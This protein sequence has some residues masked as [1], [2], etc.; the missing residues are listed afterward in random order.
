MKGRR[1][2]AHH[3]LRAHQSS[4]KTPTRPYCTVTVI[5]T[6]WES[7]PATA[8]TFTCVVP[9][10]VPVVTFREFPQAA[11]NPT[12]MTISTSG[13]ATLQDSSRVLVSNNPKIPAQTNRTRTDS[14]VGLDGCPTH[15]VILAAAFLAVVVI[16][17]C[18]VPAC[19]PSSVTEGGAKAHVAAAGRLLQAKET[20]CVEP[21]SGVTVIAELAVCPAVTVTIEGDAERL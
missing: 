17:T 10:G 15:P 20:V 6:E 11:T 5:D 16:I 9:I 21:C 19:V 14:G 4:S 1:G 3:Y 12:E 7:V 8:V 13:N 18:D 2:C